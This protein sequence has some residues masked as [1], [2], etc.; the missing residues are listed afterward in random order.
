MK[1][2]LALLLITGLLAIQVHGD[3]RRYVWTYEYQTLHKGDAELESYTEFSHMDTDSGRQAATSLQ[4]EYEIGMNERFD[5]GIYQKFKQ[6]YDSPLSY[7]GFKLRFRYRLREKRQWFMDPLIYLEYKSNSALND[8]VLETKLILA[9]DFDKFNLSLNPVL[10]FEFGED[11][12]ETK[13]EY[14][15][16]LSYELHPLLTLGLELKGDTESYYWGPT[17]SHGK[18]ELWFA[19]GLLTPGTSGAEL[20]RKI[21]F[22]IGVG[23]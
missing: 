7:D 17:I 2:K 10:E 14:T 23:L 22:I 18:E 20:D 12:T 8:N 9:R 1:I 15:S 19:I 11:E 4:Y 6:A 16:G 13:F 21:R 5:V 3:G